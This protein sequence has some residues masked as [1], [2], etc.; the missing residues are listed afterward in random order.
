MHR[1]VPALFAADRI[2]RAGIAE[3]RMQSVVAA[4][5]MRVTDGMGR[6]E[7]QHVETHR[8][9]RRQPRN[10]IVERAVA[11]CAEHG[12]RCLRAREQLVPR[13]ETRS[14]EHTSELQS[15]MRI[16]YAVSRLK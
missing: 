3:C 12:W 9:Y 7:I 11:R 16:S 14:E 4:L 15:L 5:A 10:D 13:G 8:A 2:R 6:R 1:V